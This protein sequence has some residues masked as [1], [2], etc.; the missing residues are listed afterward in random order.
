MSLNWNL[1]KVDDFEDT[2]TDENKAVTES[3]IFYTIFVGMS[4]ITEENVDNFFQR[5]YTYEK[6][7]GPTI[8]YVDK[9]NNL[10]R[11]YIKFNDVKRLIGLR[12]NADN[13]TDAKFKTRIFKRSFEEASSFIRMASGS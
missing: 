6:L 8:S 10:C 1:S 13:L 7:F 4:Q 2:L 12:T 9:D 5:V 3:I 11:H